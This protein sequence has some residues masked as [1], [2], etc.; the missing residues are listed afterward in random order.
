MTSALY[1][2][3]DN[4]HTRGYLP[5]RSEYILVFGTLCSRTDGVKQAQY[6]SR[7]QHG[8]IPPADKMKSSFCTLTSLFCY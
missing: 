7:L 8:T 5:Q 4:Q 3:V 6:F 2:V 1:L